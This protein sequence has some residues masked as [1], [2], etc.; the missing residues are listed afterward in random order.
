MTPPPPADPPALPSLGIDVGGTSVK[1]ALLD[2]PDANGRRRVAW[3]GKSDRYAKPDAAALRAAIAGAV[4]GRLDGVAVGAVG[5]C[6][7]GLMDLSTRRVT[8]AVNVPGLVGLP[9]DTLAAD[10]L[11][12]P[13][14]AIGPTTVLNDGAAT[15]ADL[16][17]TR[18]LAGRVLVLAL[19]T[20]VG[21][22]VLDNVG[23]NETPYG[24]PLIVEGTSPGHLGQLDVTLDDAPPVPVAPDGG[25]GGLEGY[26]GAPALHARYGPRV[27]YDRLDESAPPLRALAR[28]VRI[29]HALY[30][31]DHIYLAGGVGLRLAPALPVLRRLVDA[32][33]TSVARRTCAIACADH[34]HH[35]AQGAA[36]LALKRPSATLT[37]RRPRRHRAAAG[38]A[39]GRTA[40]AARTARFG[41]RG[42]A[43]VARSSR[44]SGS[45]ARSGIGRSGS[46]S[47]RAIGPEVRRLRLTRHPHD[48][49]GTSLPAR[50]R[51]RAAA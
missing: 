3:V 47:P 26:V 42:R 28:A 50:R 37:P 46:R 7:P 31:P 12:L 24:V 40:A 16:A 20:G 32:D 1:A 38:R 43:A 13:A 22:A 10:A 2:A 36:R 45:P 41:R 6:V 51:S 48:R 5:L 35:A 15:A 30:R 29:A 14:D 25:R 49:P 34:D 23:S 27:P 4:A 9:L 18:P 8:L 17:A 44:T 21:A 39:A 11:R 33:L 19:G